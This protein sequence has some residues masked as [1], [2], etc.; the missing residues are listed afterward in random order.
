MLASSTVAGIVTLNLNVQPVHVPVECPVSQMER[1]HPNMAL[2]THPSAQ[3]LCQ[4][5]D[6][7]PTPS[8]CLGLMSLGQP[9]ERHDFD[10]FA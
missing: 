8:I 9:D 1:K 5:A 6:F 10:A 7:D 4:I 2:H 3:A